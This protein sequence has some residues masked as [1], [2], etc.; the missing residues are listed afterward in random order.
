MIVVFRAFQDI[1]RVFHSVVKAKPCGSK[2]HSEVRISIWLVVPNQVIQ[3]CIKGFLATLGGIKLIIHLV[4]TNI[5][6]IPESGIVP[7]IP[8]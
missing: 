8:E 4:P 3:E 2:V 1:K 6:H 7:V 5:Q